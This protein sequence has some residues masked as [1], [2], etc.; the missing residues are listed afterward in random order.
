[1]FFA[2]R[3]I[4][5]MEE[6]WLILF[7]MT[8]NLKEYFLED[9]DE[10]ITKVFRDTMGGQ[11]AHDLFIKY[12]SNQFESDGTDI[13]QQRIEWW[14]TVDD[15]AGPIP[16]EVYEYSFGELFALHCKTKDPEMQDLLKALRDRKIMPKKQDEAKCIII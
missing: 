2:P 11:F 12:F 10:E 1:M 3:D 7:M 14:M 15:R 16:D 8:T 6:F 5:E 13:L 9:N 4:K